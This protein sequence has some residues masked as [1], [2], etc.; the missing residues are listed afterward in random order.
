M[1]STVKKQ[2]A[3]MKVRTVRDYT[4][5]ESTHL[6]TNNESAIQAHLTHY[7][8]LYLKEDPE[9]TKTQELSEIEDRKTICWNTIC[10]LA[11]AN[12]Y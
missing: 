11:A 12:D 8:L 9:I 1:E 2:R 5:M 6:S 10:C 3:P 4:G 7:G